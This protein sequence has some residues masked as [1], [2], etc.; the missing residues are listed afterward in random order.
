M[1]SRESRPRKYSRPRARRA[2]L[3][4]GSLAVQ[5]QLDVVDGLE[6]KAA[7]QFPEPAVDRAPM[8]EVD[9][10]HSPAA[11]RAHQIA[12]RI[13]HLPELDFPRTPPPSGFGHQRRN[14]LPFLVRQV[15]RVAL[16]LLRDLG[17][18]ATALLGPHQ[19]LGSQP[20]TKQNP[21]HTDFPNGLLGQNR[22][23]AK[24]WSL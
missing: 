22:S 4:P 2:R 10:Q 7:G 18:P 6:Q 16:G 15:R 14:A 9:R 23:F 11:A 20:S 3:A 5:H 1:I 13:D 17:H 24:T 12:H 19:E 8:T 21:A